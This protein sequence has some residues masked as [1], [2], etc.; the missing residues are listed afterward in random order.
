MRIGSLFA[1]IGGLDLAVES[2]LDARTVWQLDL[3]GADVRRR[4]WPDAQQI[5]ADV[6]TVD[7]A[8]LPA[9]DV[10]I[11]GFPCQDL[12]VAGTGAGLEGARSGLYRELLRIARGLAPEVIVI[13]NVPAL[14]TRYRQRLEDDLAAEGYGAT[15]C[16][17]RALDAGAPHR[18]SRVFVFALRGEPHGGVLDAPRHGAW[19]PDANERQWATPLASDATGNGRSPKW[20]PLN[21]QVRPWPTPTAS[22]P[23]GSEPIASF[24]ERSA[25]V[26]EYSRPVSDP[27]GVAVRRPT[28]RAWPTPTTVDAKGGSRAGVGQVQLC[29]AAAPTPGDLLNPRWVE[30]LMGLPIGWVSPDGPHLADL[31][32]DLLSAPRWP[33]GRYPKGWAGEWPGYPWEPAR[34]CPRY[35]GRAAELRAL[36]NAVVPQQALLAFRA[37]DATG[38]DA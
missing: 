7:P 2:A 38:E 37:T 5:V 13:E 20:E 16:R 21:Q 34:T 28:E 9:V 29:H 30:V 12:S 6:R 23:N 19:T 31:A 8:H 3:V 14:L 24:D 36:G 11:G 4:H 22:N 10:L 17:A 33:R 15:W 18:R 32:S 26:A 35:R 25:R 27:L 1:G